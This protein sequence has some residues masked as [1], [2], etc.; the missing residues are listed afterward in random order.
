MRKIAAFV[1]TIALSFA[2]AGPAFA[3]TGKDYGTHHA[4]HAQESTGFT[5]EMNPGVKHQ[6]FAGWTEM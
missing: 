5:Q 4:T 3:A 1:L 2:I 6:G